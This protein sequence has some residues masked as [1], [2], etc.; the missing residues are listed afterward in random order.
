MQIAGKITV[1]FL[2]VA[3]VAGLILAD[4]SLSR[5]Y[6]AARTAWTERAVASVAATPAL[7]IGVYTSD[8][9]S[10][11]RS[12]EEFLQTGPNADTRVESSIAAI[13]TSGGGKM[14]QRDKNGLSK[15]SL[16]PLPQL[17]GAVG[18]ADPALGAFDAVGKDTSPSARKTLLGDPG[19]LHLS[20]PILSLVNPTEAGLGQADFAAA[21]IN[22]KSNRSR[23]VMGYL[24]LLQ[25]ERPLV[26]SALATTARLLSLYALLMIACALLLYL[27][28]RWI[29]APLAQ[30]RMVAREVIEGE[31]P[32]PLELEASGASGEIIEGFNKLIDGVTS[33]Q[34]EIEV[35]RRML[36][37]KVDESASKLSQRDE[38]LSRA[39]EEITEANQRLHRLA[40]YDSLT[41]LPNK[42]L[43]AEQLRLLLPLS[44][45]SGQP[46]ALLILS[47]VQFKRINT[48]LGRRA[49]DAL[50][51]EVAKRLTGC[52]RSSDVVGQ[53]D[54][55]GPRIDVSRLGGDEF[56]LVLNQL[57]DRESARVV[58]QRVVDA[59]RAPIVIEGHELVVTPSI[60]IAVAPDDGTEVDD[61]MRA[62]A[63]AMHHAREKPTGGFEMYKK[64]MDTGGLDQIK[65]EADL[66]KA[67][68]R[69]E[70]RLH[71]QP[72]VDTVD[73]SIIAAEALL[74]WEHPEFGQVPPFR[75]ITLAQ[76]IG[77]MDQLG[78]W[79][80]REACRQLASFRDQGLELPRV[81]VNVARLQFG[82]RFTN[83]LK[84]VLT[85]SN[86][87]ADSIELG[88]S[89]EILIDNDTTT[90]RSLRELADM[91]VYLAVD[92]FGTTHA[93]LTYLSEYPFNELKI[94][95]SF[96]SGCDTHASNTSLVKAIVAMSKSLQL[97]A[98]AEGVEN[99]EEFRFLSAL[100][101]RAMQGYFFSKPVPAQELQKLL[102]IPWCFMSQ[103]Q[104]IKFADSQQQSSQ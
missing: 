75:F 32:E 55:A 45:R 97:S 68:E 13:Y 73:G 100:G 89:E 101:V 77:M 98:V 84:E 62:A 28:L 88:L 19:T 57:D 34:K 86:L 103:I 8:L 23:V 54:A 27:A 11:H 30:L 33:Y 38:E 15:V 96:V 64:D 36:S 93:P 95:R 50:L 2:V 87:P 17:R 51:T 99:E 70:L 65:L 12:L 63:S 72:Q 104:R 81:A 80:L 41:A 35:D 60:G 31:T 42:T 82:E 58:A 39:T 52:L 37:L 44:V 29:T 26:L 71:Y 56:S 22:P 53:Y 67:V 46:L 90:I 74:R 18:V 83:T 94:D 66:R 91:G 21:I 25:S 48:T 76:D 16:P 69:E 3:S 61:L 4:Q 78:D 102:G 24:Q 43:F 79:V 10:L 49:A 40:Y 59:L 47:L 85:Q 92:N 1:L 5:E 7:Q 14:L 6:E 20:V 9:S